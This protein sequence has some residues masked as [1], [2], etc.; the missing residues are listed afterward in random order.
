MNYSTGAMVAITANLTSSVFLMIILT[1]N[2]K[3]KEKRPKDRIFSALVA[4][5]LS[6][7]LLNAL[8][9]ILNGIVY[10]ADFNFVVTLIA[11]CLCIP[12]SGLMVL[13][14]INVIK[15][16]HPISDIYTKI[17]IYAMVVFSITVF[18]LCAGGF[19]FTIEDGVYTSGPLEYSYM[20]FVFILGYLY[21]TFIILVHAK[22]LGLK[23]SLILLLYEII[24]AILIGL[25]AESNY[26]IIDIVYSGLAISLT[27]IYVLLQ[28]DS[29]I[30]HLEKEKALSR[31]SNTDILTGL[32]N[33]RAYTDMIDNLPMGIPVGIIF[34]DVNR[35]KF[36]NDNFGHTTG[37]KL[38]KDFADIL[39]KSFNKDDIFRISGDEFVVVFRGDISGLEESFDSFVKEID[40]Y[41]YKIASYGKATGM[42]E[43]FKAL[44]REAEAKMYEDKKE[45]YDLHPEENRRTV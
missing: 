6:A 5:D 45:Y 41:K 12:V 39:N 32:Q 21:N 31:I 30:M 9:N 40:G 36:H 17:D 4:V 3:I 15:E 25:V 13:Y 38:L 16:K 2:C 35:L 43:D 19:I 37:D 29:E 20:V 23:D 33:R 22:S 26:V 28:V 44:L 14:T 34:N 24:P 7:L 8:C 10:M 18:I 1:G 11:T 27:V 42:S